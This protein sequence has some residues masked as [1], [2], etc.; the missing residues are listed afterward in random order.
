[1]L[2]LKPS[3]QSAET[4]DDP[5]FSVSDDPTFSVSAASIYASFIPSATNVDG[6]LVFAGGGT[7]ASSSVAGSVVAVSSG[8]ININL[9]FDSAAMAAPASFR[10]GIVQAAS[11]LASTISDKITVN[12]NIDYSGTGGGAAAGPDNGQFVSYSTVRSDLISHA[13]A[14]DTTFNA[15]PGGSSVQGQ[16]SVAVWNAQLKLFGIMS[17]NDV[18]TDDGSA[19]FATDINSG[20]LVGVALHELTHAL[21]RIPYGPQPDVFDLFRFTSPGVRLFQGTATAPA[22]YFSVDGGATK[23]ADFGRASDSS[24]FL[25]SGVQGSNDPFNEFYTGSTNQTL[26]L[27]DKEILDALGFHLTS[28]AT[29]VIEAAGSTSLVQV[30]SGFFLNP[31]G[32]GTGPALKFG[33]SPVTAAQLGVW[34]PIAVEAVSGGYEVAFKIASTDQY[35]VW[36]TDSNGNYTGN[37]IGT[38]SG[39]T[40]ALEALETSFQ[41]DLNGD[42]V[43]GVPTRV[44]EASG[45]TSLVAVGN[46]FF[47]DNISSGTG[48]VLK[49]GGSPVTAGQLGVWAPIAVEA[50]SGGYEVAFK[51]AS[52]GQYTVWSTDSNG[53]Y[54]GSLIG[55]VSGS[56]AALE[57]LETSF[58]QD[59]NGDGVIGVPTRVIE[60]SGSTSLVAVGNNFFLD[61]ISSGT[62][63]VLKFGGSPVTAGQLGGWAPIGVEAI[64]GGYEVAFKM[65]GADQY[66]VWSTDSSGNYTGNLIGTVSGSSA[67]LEALETSFQQ[68]LNGDGV[69]GVPTAVIEA[70]GSAS[71]VE[72]GNNFFL[73]SISSGTGP[74]LKFGGSPVTAGQLGSWAPIAVEAVS[75]GYEVAFKIASTDQYTVWSTDGNGNYTGNLIGTVSGSSAALEAL[76]TSFHQDLNGDG[77]IGIPP[78]AAAFTSLQSAGEQSAAFDGTTLVL[79]TPST[80]TGRI[81]GSAA[82]SDQID[83]H[84]MNSNTIHSSFDASTDSLTVSDGT[85]AATLQFLGHYSSDSFHFAD[86]GHGGTLIVAAGP[87]SSPA[88]SAATSAGGHDIFVFAANFGQVTIANFT[89]TTD[90][91]EFN[92]TVFADTAAVLA[93]A[94]DDQAGNAVLTDAAHDTI[95]L[96]HIT[97]AQL[98]AHQTAFH[99]V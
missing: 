10:A 12:L 89:P 76:E 31:V 88:D 60:A 95:T 99:F 42:G 52:T 46:N 87:A 85:T 21:G 50:V 69:I 98:V 3:A 18:T 40:A 75:G 33:G 65:A 24:D 70:T 48:P 82:G 62:G 32:G 93:A 23:L 27:V 14:G 35:A 49:F 54:T 57:A 17:A 64:S 53:N 5:A 83:L 91:I 29:V 77:V 63:P 68:D 19:Y 79:T 97:T 6:H 55:T 38:V 81:I 39:S 4:A 8:G 67:A 59:L 20:L 9:L 44:I 71:L 66:I 73:D 37:L 86:D 30:A 72:V 15:L 28:N 26:S 74:V 22:A 80:F 13:T 34:A 47:L 36:S 25:N 11:I 78:A 16:S 94:H 92:H 1:M 43:I 7:A 56:T 61:N 96:Q 51:I 45:S 84:G 2:D 58:Q 90:S 41:Q